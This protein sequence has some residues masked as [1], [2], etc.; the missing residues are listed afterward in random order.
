MRR[1]TCGKRVLVSPDLVETCIPWRDCGVK[2]THLV[3]DFEL[4]IRRAGKADFAV[5]YQPFC[6]EDAGLC[7][8]WDDA[9]YNLP[10]GRY[11]AVLFFKAA[12]CG[13]FDLVLDKPVPV[14]LDSMTNTFEGSNDLCS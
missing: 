14:R 9:L 7:F 4:K 3:T 13:Q 10:A 5:I 6:A 2:K 1:P 8:L 12:E 11:D